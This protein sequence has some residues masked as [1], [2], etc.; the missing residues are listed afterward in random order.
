MAIGAV[1][2]ALWL[3]GGIAAS[4]QGLGE[5]VFGTADHPL[6][7]LK[8]WEYW[9]LIVAGSAV[10]I[11]ACA[12][13]PELVMASPPVPPP[14]VAKPVKP[15]VPVTEPA[16]PPVTN[17]PGAFPKLKCQGLVANGQNSTVVLNG[18]TVAI[19]EMIEG[20]TVVAIEPDSVTVELKGEQMVITPE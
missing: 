5:G 2:L 7:F 20:V 4:R 11:Y 1:G 3:I 6:V 14:P 17:T 8:S 12:S 13:R 10:L 18:R 15:V 19:G 9:G 16:P